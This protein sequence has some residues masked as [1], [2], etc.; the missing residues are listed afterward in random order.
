MFALLSLLFLQGMASEDFQRREDASDSARSWGI[1]F[2]LLAP[3]IHPNPEV[4]T[5]INRA[6]DGYPHNIKS[7][8]YWLRNYD[9]T[10]KSWHLWV[11]Y[12]HGSHI[13]CNSDILTEIADHTIAPEFDIITW[14]S[15]EGSGMAYEFLE[16]FPKSGLDIYD[17]THRLSPFSHDR[18]DGFIKK[19]TVQ[20]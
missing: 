15:T 10:Y 20:N 3:D 14:R 4:S 18:F 16:L 2:A 7:F 13:Y 12:N 9:K 1:V 19:G 17:L 11:V 8:E 5:R 6:K